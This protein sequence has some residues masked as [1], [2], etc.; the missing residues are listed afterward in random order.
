MFIYCAKCVFMVE[1]VTIDFVKSQSVEKLYKS[2]GG[3]WIGIFYFILKVDNLFQCGTEK[4]QPIKQICD[5]YRHCF[6][7]H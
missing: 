6:R 5:F 2:L 7:W 4:V 1:D 3:T